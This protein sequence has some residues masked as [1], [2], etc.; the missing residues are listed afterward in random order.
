MISQSI[1]FLDIETSGMNPKYSRIIE[2]GI[3]KVQNDKTINKI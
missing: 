1:C 3:L 2:I